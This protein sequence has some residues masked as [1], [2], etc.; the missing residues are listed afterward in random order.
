[1]YSVLPSCDVTVHDVSAGDILGSTGSTEDTWLT[2]FS[3]FSAEHRLD[4]EQL[5][6]LD[7]VGVVL[8]E[9]A[10]QRPAPPCRRHC[11]QTVPT[12]FLGREMVSTLVR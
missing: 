6:N 1:M 4:P 2:A 12:P 9:E 11:R 10:P 8:A 7:L 5:R 3:F